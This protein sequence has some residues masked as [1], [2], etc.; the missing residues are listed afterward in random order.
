M[1]GNRVAKNEG[2]KSKLPWIVTGCVAS[3]LIAGYLGVCAWAGSRNSMLPNVSVAGVDVSN[4]TLEQARSAVETA[5]SQKGQDISLT[6]SYEGMSSTLNA[7]DM[8]VDAA[9]SAEDAW[10]IG[11]ENFFTGGPQLLGH[12]FGMSS[13]VPLVI[14]ED[15]PALKDLVD[16][17]ARKVAESSESPGYELKG[18]QLVMTKGAPVLSV[19]WG[20]VREE[21]EEKLQQSFADR[22]S[23]GKSQVDLTI[24]LQASAGE[25]KDPDFE[26]IYAALAAEPRD[27]QLDPKTLEVSDHAV[28]LDFDLQALKD[29]YQS[30]KGGET[31]SIPVTVLQPKVTREDLEG[32]LFR[33]VLAEAT[34]HV[35]GSA[36]RKNN[37]K[38]AMAAC[39]NIILLPGEEFSY[40]RTTGERTTAKGYRGAPAYIGGATVDEVGGGV[41]QGSSTIYYA[42][43]HT[44]LEIVER[45]PHRYAVTY[46]PDG[47]DATVNYGSIDFRFKN[48]TDYPIKIVTSSYDVKGA[49]KLNVKIYGT[50]LDGSYAKPSSSGAFDIIAPTVTYVADAGVP[51][52][53]LVLD[54]EQNAY[55]G[56]S[57]QTFRT[58]YAADGTQLE[59]QNLG[60]SSYKMR[61]T[62]YHYNPAD[63]HPSTWVGGQP[64]VD[65]GTTTPVDPGTTTPVDPGT[66]TPVDPGTTTPVDPGTTTP[67]DPG[68]TTPVDPGTT[69]PV[70]PGTTTPVDPGTTV[71]ADPSPS[72]APP[73]SDSGLNPLPNPARAA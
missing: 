43:L 53:S 4:M 72:P 52:G 3:V 30:A 42:V 5:V 48:N 40:N 13:Q 17:M 38:L 69:T 68:T 56:K 57:V 71:P 23:G 25:I 60:V 65:P 59:R 2:K 49:C 26:A 39:N 8:S 64:P 34:T 46:V 47:M 12:M 45:R 70:D 22:F 61:P 31:F 73:P 20:Q 28:G 35:A 14:P 24:Q 10:R 19:D 66:T 1:E 11:R 54:R 7:G 21:A 50:N 44:S 27:A 37:I 18:D 32:R 15:E 67:V 16:G 6:L 36:A 62:V 29:A 58:I 41:C 9:Q 33:D 51:R 63:G 55:R